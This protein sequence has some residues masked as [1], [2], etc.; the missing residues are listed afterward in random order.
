MPEIIQDSC[1]PI[2][3]CTCCRMFKQFE[4]TMPKE[5]KDSQLRPYEFDGVLKV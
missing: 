2:F 4:K 3:L 1:S 5:W